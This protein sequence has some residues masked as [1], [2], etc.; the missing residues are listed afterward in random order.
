M[1]TMTSTGTSSGLLRITGLGALVFL[2]F[3]CFYLFI[4]DVLVRIADYRVDSYYAYLHENAKQTESSDYLAKRIKQ[5]QRQAQ[6][7]LKVAGYA[8]PMPEFFVAAGRFYFAKGMQQTQR[9]ERT[10]WLK[11]AHKNWLKAHKLR[12]TWP[13]YMLPLLELELALNKP[14]A[15][16][17]KR[18]QQLL[19]S[20]QNETALTQVIQHLFI[21]HWPVFSQ[22]QKDWFVASLKRLSPAQLK[23][24][25]TYAK[26]VRNTAV[27]CNYIAWNTVKEI[28]R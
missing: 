3:V 17:Q 28:C 7:S 24:R 12:P 14:K 4:S 21:Q 6:T 18:M 22:A 16:S 11:K 8:L 1:T 27:V 25:Y 10:K 5:V 2:A 9:K 19:D 23:A 20:G 26:S 15:I 13:Y